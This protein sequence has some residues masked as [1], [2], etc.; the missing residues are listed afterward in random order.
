MCCFS[1]FLSTVGV[2]RECE[3]R[4][5]RKRAVR[6][7]FSVSHFPSPPTPCLLHLTPPLLD[8]QLLLLLL[9]LLLVHAAAEVPEAMIPIPVL[10]AL[11]AVLPPLSLTIRSSLQNLFQQGCL[12]LQPTS[13]A[14]SRSPASPPV[15]AAGASSINPFSLP[16]AAARHVEGQLVEK[17]EAQLV[18]RRN[19]DR[20]GKEE[21][22]DEG[23]VPEG[24]GWECEE[25]NKEVEEDW[26][27]L[28]EGAAGVI[29]EGAR[30]S[31]DDSTP[32]RAQ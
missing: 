7:S 10:L 22:R 6:R 29:G 14:S 27:E 21:E 28:L 3:G 11:I 30:G 23:Q 25:E 19:L 1:N 8:L 24:E 2:V 31:A 12:M 32:K 9:A 17:V 5:A 15:P 20:E 4:G 13:P 18:G 26:A 16:N